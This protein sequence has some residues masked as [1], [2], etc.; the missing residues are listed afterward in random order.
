MGG[1]VEEVA[2]LALQTRGVG[3]AL[4]T[5]HYMSLAVQTPSCSQVGTCI[6][7]QTSGQVQTVDAVWQV[8]RALVALVGIQIH[9][10]LT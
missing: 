1:G 2:A 4:D 5:A 10:I 9:A 7:L 3:V 8:G 6:A